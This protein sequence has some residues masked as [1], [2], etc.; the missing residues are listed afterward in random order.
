MSLS[1]VPARPRVWPW[2]RTV[3]ACAALAASLALPRLGFAADLIKANNTNG[4][5]LGTSWVGGSA[6]TAADVGVWNSTVTAANT[7]ALGGD[8]SWQGIRIANPGGAVSIS[9]GNTLTLGTAGIDMASATQNLSIASGVTLGAA[10]SWNVASSR[11]LAV[12][13]LLAGSAALTKDGAGTLSLTSASNSFSGGLT[14]NAGAITAVGGGLGSGTVSVTAASAFNVSGTAATF[15]NNF[16]IGSFTGNWTLVTPDNSSTVFNGTI[17]GGGANTVLFFQGGGSGQNTGALTLNGVNTFAGTIDV[18]RGPLIL[19]NAAAAGSAKIRLNSNANPNGALQLGNFAISNALEIAAG[20][21]VGVATGNSATISGVVSS[22]STTAFVKV[23]DGTLTFTGTNTYTGATNVNAGTLQIGSGGTVGTIPATAVTIASGA[24]LAINRSDAIT[25]GG[26][27]SGSGSLRKS[28]AGTLTLSG[29]NTFSGGTTWEAGSISIASGSGLGT[30]AVTLTGTAARTLT[31]A[32]NAAQTFAPAIVLP[33]PSAA[34]SYTIVKNSSGQT[35]GT[36]LNLTGVISGGGPN[37]TLFFNSSQGGDSTTTYTLSGANTFRGTINVNRGA[38]VVGN[39]SSFGDPANVIRIDSNANA[40]LGNLRFNLPMTV[41]NP[42]VINAAAHPI[43]TNEFAVT[44]AGVVSGN[45]LRKLGTGTLSLTAT[46][47]YTAG[48]IIDAGTLAIGA[49]GTTGSITGNV[50]NNATLAFNRSDAISFAGVISGSGAV[51][52][53]AAG[54][55]TLT[56]ANTYAGATFVEAGTLSLGAAASLASSSVIVSPGATLDVSALGGGF[57]LG[58][59]KSLGGSGTVSGSVTVGSGGT[60]SP[61]MSPGTLTTGPLTWQAGGN[62]NWQ[63][64]STQGTAGSQW[65]LISAD[66]LTLSGL[67]AANRFTLNL[68][69]LASTGPDVNGPVADFDPTAAGSWRIVNAASAISGFDPAQFNVVTAAAN[70]TGGFGNSLQGGSFRVA[71]AGD[72]RGLDLVFTPGQTTLRW[73]ADGVAAGGGGTWSAAGQTWNDGSGVVAWSPDKTA[74][75]SG[76]PGTVTITDPVTASKGLDF[77]TDGFTLAGST[78]TLSG[79]SAAVNQIAVAA[80]ATATIA[81]P[82]GGTTG[83]TK[84]GVGTLAITTPATLSGG[85]SITDGT[86]A[87]TAPATISGGVSVAAGTVRVGNGGTNGS[88]A[89]DVTLAAGTTL[90]FDRSDAA[91]FAGGIVGGGSVRQQGVGTLVLSGTN[92]FSGPLTVAAGSVSVASDA[93]LG[94]VPGTA[95]AGRLVLSDTTLAATAS[96][97]LAATRGLA[98]GPASGPGSGTIDVAG[99]TTL[100]YAGAI[101]NNGTAGTLVKSG[102][103]TL[104]LSGTSTYSNGT[105]LTSGRLEFASG[106][107]IGTGIVTLEGGTLAYAG[108]TGTVSRTLNV[109]NQSSFDVPTGVQLTWTGNIQGTGTRPASDGKLVKTGGGTLLLNGNF[110]NQVNGIRVAEGTLVSQHGT[111]Y[112]LL[113]YLRGTGG[114]PD[115]SPLE[116]AAAGAVRIDGLRQFPGSVTQ[117]GTTTYANT[118]VILEGGQFVFVA[119]TT[120]TRDNTIGSLSFTAGGGV[121]IEAN[122]RVDLNSLGGIA[123]S[124]VGAATISGAGTLN[125]VKRAA[126][127]TP[128]IDVALAAPLTISTPLTSTAFGNSTGGLGLTKTGLGTLTL[129]GANT[130]AGTTSILAGT[131]ALGPTASLATAVI[132]V[133]SGATFDASALAGG[134]TLGTGQRLGGAGSILGSL[135]FGS[136]AKLAFSTT[137]TLTMSS[138]TASFFA[139]TPGFQF[140]IDDLIGLDATTPL[141]TYR[142]ISGSVD[143]SNLDNF[144][145]GNPY[146]LGDGRSAY[147]ESGGLSVVVVPEPGSLALVCLGV[148]VAAALRTRRLRA[149]L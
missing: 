134:F 10:Q 90:V 140:G 16:S 107:A 81:A 74:V 4:L 119:P 69:S 13:G 36:D 72:S 87:I 124:G 108:P 59:G 148:L 53:L 95:T 112:F 34:T 70:G 145:S 55:T 15:A 65:D 54:T 11:T 118:P 82:L 47:T 143:T 80:A 67:D 127:D 56:A 39:A 22:T 113:G 62:Y 98:I 64:V 30:G 78:L 102:S 77:A 111:N 89:A 31:V 20:A 41:P 135:T 97:T 27:I 137:D 68:W 115:G 50:T 3:V 147:F 45:A 46:N 99:G 103:G 105:R 9:A 130:Y 85:V 48:T 91:S 129:G 116:I 101:A 133:S 71:L 44:L 117:Y 18:Q 73:M 114:L 2:L 1:A 104:A 126:G 131:L 110:D 29:T 57:S 21:L 125:F 43:N 51:R 66:S 35:T 120:G 8:L 146:T 17:S 100:S 26:T 132:G 93:S 32:N 37:A 6:P 86:L 42:I 40:A 76:T 25:V 23:G 24:T 5:G 138:G 88:L 121:S 28:A 144:G 83:M 123:T 141:G 139:G 136:G 84:T 14:V 61:G 92:T 38:L 94:A 106:G 19:G 63:I 142:L 7:A 12:S 109:V 58:T 149:G 75:F 96:F 52:K 122:N 60:L 33:A 128:T 49:G 79:A